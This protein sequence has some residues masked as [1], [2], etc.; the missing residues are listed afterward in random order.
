MRTWVCRLLSV[1]FLLNCMTP[2]GVAQSSRRT[3]KRKHT[4]VAT[5]RAQFE[6][7]LE[8]FVNNTQPYDL[9]KVEKV[10]LENVLKETDLTDLERE[11]AQLELKHV[12][13]NID[14]IDELDK[15]NRTVGMVNMTYRTR[16]AR[17]EEQEAELE[18]MAALRNFYQQAQSSGFIAASVYAMHKQAEDMASV[19]KPEVVPS[20]DQMCSR[21]QDRFVCANDAIKPSLPMPPQP[22]RVDPS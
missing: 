9:W 22:A 10:E 19:F 2:Y 14:F 11:F 7:T 12:Q 20:V 15:D 21:E 13:T 6:Q 5:R 3:S 17:L 18:K 4:S 8:D 1:V 16:L